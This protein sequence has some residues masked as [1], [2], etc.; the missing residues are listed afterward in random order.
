MPTFH[1][2][3]GFRIEVRARDHSPPHFHMIGPDFHALIDI[4]TLKVLQGTYTRKALAE[5]IAWASGQTGALMQE[6]RRLNE[7]G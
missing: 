1:R 6:W 5:V 3:A 4:R 2:F 7:R